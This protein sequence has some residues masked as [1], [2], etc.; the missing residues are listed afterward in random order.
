MARVLI[1][2]DDEKL[3]SLL[4]EYLKGEGYSVHAEADGERAV[5]EAL[6]NCYDIMV[7]DVMMPGLSGLEVLRQVRT[8]STLPIIMLTARGDD[9]DRIMG[10]ELGADDYVPKPCT[11]RE[12]AARIRAITRRSGATSQPPD[13]EKALRAAGLALWPTERRAEWLGKPLRLTSTEFTLLEVLARNAGR[14]V[15]KGQLSELVLGRPAER[16]DRTIDVHISGIRKKL[17]ALPDGRS[18]IVAVFRQGY[19]LLKVNSPES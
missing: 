8:Q 7:L 6:K 19:Q 5:T 13:A 15:N 18:P 2:D 14:P 3:T 1:V 12:L 11:P 10:L 16:Y 17:G 9:V 4:A